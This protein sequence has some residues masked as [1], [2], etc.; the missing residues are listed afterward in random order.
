MNS[1]LT[2][3]N[4]KEKRKTVEFCNKFIWNTKGTGG[5]QVSSR[6]KVQIRVNAADRRRHVSIRDFWHMYRNSLII[7]K[8]IWGTLSGKWFKAPLSIMQQEWI[9]TRESQYHFLFLSF[10]SDLFCV[11]LSLCFSP[12]W[13]QWVNNFVWYG[14]TSWKWPGIKE[15]LILWKTV[16]IPH[17]EFK[18]HQLRF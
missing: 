7:L 10:S 9:A 4:E 17:F 16:P 5:S 12:A 13:S 8:R 3:G 14:A 18:N 11:A 2:L 1:A 15:Q 6:E